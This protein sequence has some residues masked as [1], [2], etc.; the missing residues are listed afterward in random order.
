M[1]HS[2]MRDF[3]QDEHGSWAFLEWLENPEG[4]KKS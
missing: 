4:S 3:A 2:A 1:Q